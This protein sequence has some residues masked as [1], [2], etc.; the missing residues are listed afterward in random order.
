[1]E[2]LLVSSRE[3]KQWKNIRCITLPAIQGEAEIL[4]GHAESFIQL[5][6]G[7]LVLKNQKEES[8]LINGGVCYV[9]NDKVLIII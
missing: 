2:C 7:K 8:F 5:K 1:M 3:K 4:P 6:A 9:Y